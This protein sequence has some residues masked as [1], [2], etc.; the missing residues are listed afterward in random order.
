MKLG[1]APQITPLETRHDKGAFSCG[2]APLDRYLHRQAS[3]DHKRRLAAVFVLQEAGYDEIIGFYALSS[4]SIDPG[5]WPS[6]IAKKLPSARPIPCT[7]LGQFAV[8]EVWQGKGISSWLFG[9]VLDRVWR[10]AQQ[11]GS[12][13]LVV[14]AVDGDAKR[15][16]QKMGFLEF[17]DTPN[18]LFQPMKTI[19]ALF[20]D[21]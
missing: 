13:A 20:A 8:A 15:Y 18:R 4:I 7:L 6:A 10:Q 14:D 17:P 19:G 11:V 12:F 1:F 9:A 3:Q 21:E 2:K 5:I 16:W